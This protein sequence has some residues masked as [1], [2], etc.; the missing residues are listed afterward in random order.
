MPNATKDER[1]KKHKE[2][3]ASR[4]GA[5][6]ETK[7]KAKGKAKERSQ[8]S[9]HSEGEPR[10]P[11]PARVKG[12]AK[13]ETATKSETKP[14][15]AKL[16]AANSDRYDLYQRSVNSPDSDVDFL[17]RA[18]GELRD[19]RRPQ[20]LREDFCGTANLSAEWLARDPA[21][22]AEGFDLDPEPIAWGQQV[23]F[24]AI[25][26]YRERMTFHVADVRSRSLA[27]PDI[28]TAPNFSYWCFR[29]REELKTGSW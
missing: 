16:T 9:A 5:R 28:T 3:E 29:T 22:T 18:Y 25:D 11:K 6:K 8:A 2:A 13:L 15:K 26:D 4:K 27:K 20:H 21:F 23:N 14:K 19:G 12:K 1:K 7:S 24:A 17:I 10:S